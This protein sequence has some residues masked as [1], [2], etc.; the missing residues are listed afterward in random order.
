[1]YIIHFGIMSEY[2]IFLIFICLYLDYKNV[3]LFTIYIEYLSDF[4]S[5]FIG[6]QKILFDES[7]IFKV[8]YQTNIFILTFILFDKKIYALTFGIVSNKTFARSWSSVNLLMK[9]SSL[10]FGMNLTFSSKILQKY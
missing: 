1:M 6:N 4:T 2:L 5:C 7:K 8:Q 10:L 9:S 3:C